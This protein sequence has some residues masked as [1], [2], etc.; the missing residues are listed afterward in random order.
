MTALEIGFLVL[1]YAGLCLM[2]GAAFQ[3][4]A[5][6]GNRRE[7]RAYWDE[8]PRPC[9]GLARRDHEIEAALAKLRGRRRSRG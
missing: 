6:R 9:A 8:R 2:A 7:L 1:S 4:L 3:W 5:G